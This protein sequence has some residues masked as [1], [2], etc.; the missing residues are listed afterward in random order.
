MS[1]LVRIGL[2]VIAVIVSATASPGQSK[3]RILSDRSQ[4]AKG[5]LSLQVREMVG[6]LAAQPV[7]RGTGTHDPNVWEILFA[8][9]RRVSPNRAGGVDFGDDA[10]P[11]VYGRSLVKVPTGR[12]QRS[13]QPQMRSNAVMANRAF[14]DRLNELVRSSVDQ[15]VLVFV[16]GFNVDFAS[17]VQRATQ[18]GK[19]MPF[20]GAI[21]SYSWPS[22]GNIRNYRT[23]EKMAHS[24]IEPFTIFLTELIEAVPGNTRLNILVHSMGNRVVLGA[25]NTLP[26]SL[27]GQTPFQHI[28]LAAPDVAAD[29]FRLQVK[30]AMNLA[31]QVTLYACSDDTALKA[32]RQLHRDPGRPWVQIERAGD[33]THP[34][35]E[36]GLHTIDV[37]AVDTSFMWHSYYGSNKTVLTDL[38]YQFKRDRQPDQCPWL[39]RVATPAGSYWKMDKNRLAMMAV[40]QPH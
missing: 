40:T 33:A 10:G 8:T 39:H 35:V 25:L 17:A 5:P 3:I 2:V 1:S 29:S 38:L 15:D 22:L 12:L 24:S 18:I 37:S 28:V 16:H 23:D 27:C 36:S 20:S 19:D 34:V 30:A 4:N 6:N 31:N 13:R 7:A 11:L 9:N 14:Y 26:D 21:V 32:S